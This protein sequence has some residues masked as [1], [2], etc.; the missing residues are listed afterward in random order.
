MRKIKTTR[1]KRKVFY[2]IWKNKELL[3]KLVNEKEIE[4]QFNGKNY[5]IVSENYGDF[6]VYE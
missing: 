6:T 5:F 2:Y 1:E 4:I 3:D